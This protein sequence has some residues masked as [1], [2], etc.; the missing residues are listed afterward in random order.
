MI[1]QTN[2]QEI[3]RTAGLA[4]SNVHDEM[5]FKQIKKWMKEADP[6]ESKDMA[7]YAWSQLFL[8]DGKYVVLALFRV[9]EY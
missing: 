9:D 1:G 2:L 7:E 8:G 5:P 4:E 3:V 6:N